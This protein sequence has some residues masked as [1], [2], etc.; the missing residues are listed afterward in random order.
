MG[1]PKVGGQPGAGHPPS[2]AR[3]RPSARRRGG[4][5]GRARPPRRARAYMLW[6]QCP[7]SP[8]RGA[9]GCA[10]PLQAST[11][12]ISVC[13]APRS[14]R[15][16]RS[17]T[18][19]RPRSR[20]TASPDPWGA[21]RF[22]CSTS[23]AAP[24]VP[25]LR[26]GMLGEARDPLPGLAVV[27]ADEQARGLG[28]GPERAVRSAEAPDLDEGVPERARRVG[29]A[30]HLGEAGVVRRP[31]V[32]LAG[33]ELD[34]GSSSRRRRASATRPRRGTPRRPRPRACPSAGRR[35]R[36]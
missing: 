32:H 13:G 33:G 19:R 29:P 24:A 26:R 36:G 7:T 18:R 3:H 5:A 2:C 31:R 21:A 1:N 20:P 22:V 8:S 23:P 6:T 25:A 9:A 17:R 30:D 15:H 34:E 11:F 28:A 27:T 14:R 35:S 4:S 12:E 16:P 10:C